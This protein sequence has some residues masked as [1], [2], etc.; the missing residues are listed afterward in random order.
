MIMNY[1]ENKRIILTIIII[2]A[3]L[4]TLYNA[5]LPL[6]PDEAYYW[7]WS[8]HLDLSYYDHPPMI[9]Y[10]IA[11]FS[12]LGD[13]S[14][15]VRLP[16]VISMMIVTGVSVWFA[17][18]LF[19]QKAG[20]WALI[21][22]LVLPATMFGVTLATPDAPLMA[23]WALAMMWGYKAIFE[24][25]TPWF[26]LAGFALGCALLS[27]YTAIVYLFALLIFLVMRKREIFKDKGFY[28]AAIVA[29]LT[30]LPVIIWNARHEWISFAFQYGH[31]DGHTLTLKYMGEFIGGI[32]VLLSP[33]IAFIAFHALV[34]TREW[35]KDERIFF[36][37][38]MIVV[39]LIFF[40]YKALFARMQLNWYAMICVG[41]TIIASGAIVRYQWQKLALFGVAL[42]LLMGLVVKF[43][44]LFF[45][46]PQ[47]NI[48]NRLFGFDHAVAT[49]LTYQKE[50]DVL[51]AD[52]LTT[53][54][55]ITYYAPSHPDVIIPFETRMSQYS[56]WQKGVNTNENGV[57]LA[58]RLIEDKRATLIAPLKI[59]REGFSEKIFY[60]YR[61]TKGSS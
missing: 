50:G 43:P 34:K 2:Y 26:I 57:L 46:P 10:V 14:W 42:S 45:L 40:G 41:M 16:S 18:H 59:N 20:A 1:L 25:G 13:A 35:Y 28:I 58:T 56:F 61:I 30:F 17:S 27:K 31:G 4:Q 52:H 36:V 33:L 38:L 29:F 53:A 5:F 54:A 49:L 51:M 47:A 8:R 3:L 19:G 23:F 7:V 37:I 24:G 11:M 22:S 44:S 32:F 12:F 55:V 39:P 6:H 21:I 60:I 15:V 9:A 48:H